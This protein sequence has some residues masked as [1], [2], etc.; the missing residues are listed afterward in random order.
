MLT[1]NINIQIF[2]IKTSLFFPESESDSGLDC[3]RTVDIE[4]VLNL[5]SVTKT[6]SQPGVLAEVGPDN[7]QTHCDYES[8]RDLHGDTFLLL[9][10][11]FVQC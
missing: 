6:F 5:I 11:V 9:P 3:V 4:M 1:L 10:R 7:G 2:I 8:L